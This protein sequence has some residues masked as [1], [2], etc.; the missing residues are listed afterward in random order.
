M[1]EATQP[2]AIRLSM[3]RRTIARRMAQSW[4]TSPRVTYHMP[5]DAGNIADYRHDANARL[6]E[7]NIKITYNHIIMKAVATAL[8][9]MPE[10]NAS[11]TEKELLLHPHANIGLAVAVPGGL[12]VPNVKYCE[13]KDLRRIAVETQA[14]IASVLEGKINP[15]DLSG[16]TFTVTNLGQFGVTAFSPIINQPELAILGVCA[17]ADTPVVAD[18]GITIRPMMG[19]SLSADHRAV[20]GTEAAKFLSRIRTL[21]EHPLS[22]A[23]FAL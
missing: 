20:D 23:G 3:M 6:A 14:I 12:I 15:A 22:H 17:I 7:E 18:G 19:F 5:V 8:M 9:E 1:E 16:A 13:Q 11:I 4:E 2:K 21:L 10:I